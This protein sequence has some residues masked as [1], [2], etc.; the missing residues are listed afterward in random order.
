M[1]VLRIFIAIEI[2]Q[3][4]QQAIEKN[5]LSLRNTLNANLVRWVP[6]GNIHLTLKF[7]GDVSVSTVDLLTQML[8]VE[9]SQHSRFEMRFDG[10]GLF[11]SPRRPRVIW[12]GI[13]A[14]AGL[15]ALQRGIETATARMGYRTESRPFSPHLTIGRVK[16]TASLTDGQKIRAALD[17]TRIASLGTSHVEAVHLFKSD[18]KPSGSVYTRLFS[19]PLNQ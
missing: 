14:P 12:V 4:I 13:Q 19:A 3:D 10:L 8:K 15:E 17:G 2:P 18:L 9:A 7:L 5:T 6:A 11:P 16:Q 1:N